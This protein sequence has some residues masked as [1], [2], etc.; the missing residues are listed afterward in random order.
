MQLEVR[1]FGAFR[2]L[3]PEP[4]IQV[5]L[6]GESCSILELKAA[7]GEVLLKSEKNAEFDVRELLSK[8]A[9]AD[10]SQI[11]E[12]SAILRSGMRVAVLPPVNG[13]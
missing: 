6:L 12:D 9:I 13:G 5:T 7:I 11:L 8:T 10:E 3:S 4:L 1:L 2:N